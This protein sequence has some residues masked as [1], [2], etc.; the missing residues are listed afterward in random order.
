MAVKRLND[1]VL[2]IFE[3]PGLAWLAQHL[4][5]WVLPNHLTAIGFLGA[6]LAGA[7]FV[8]SQWSMEWLWLANLGLVA[9]WFGDS[10]DGTL[11]R[12]RKIERPRFGFFL[13]NSIDIFSQAIILLAVGVSPCA[14]F[15]VACM[16]L[17]A[18]Q[19][20]YIF[21]LIEAQVQGIQR[22]TFF[23][24]GPT[25]IRVLLVLGNLLTLAFGVVDV[26]AWLSPLAALV[27]VSIHD[28]VISILSAAGVVLLAAVAIRE[29][30]VLAVDDP[31]PVRPK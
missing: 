10:L 29:A 30:R 16:G 6:V 8:L 21:T 13:D 24:F 15:A 5:S 18:F 9:N 3:R 23:G 12:L 22:I 14:H 17:I 25:E 20:A 2:C 27:S 1:G 19:M 26:R 11:A 28:L 7:G 31:P 4:P